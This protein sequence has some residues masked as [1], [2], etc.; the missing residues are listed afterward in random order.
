MEYQEHGVCVSPS[1]HGLGVYAT[2][3][4]AECDL[5]GPIAGKVIDDPAYQ[6]DYCM[7]LGL[8]SALEP[9]APF[10]FVNHSCQPNCRLL[11]IEPNS[12]HQVTVDAGELWLEVLCIIAPGEQITIDYAWPA[13]A[14]TPCRC[15]CPECRGWIVAAT[16][17]H[18]VD[19]SRQSESASR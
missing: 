6:S 18:D 10:R 14:A 16:E 8:H 11:E 17:R 3:P 19:L 2:K 7:E 12:A 1:V 4:F 13:A 15:G 9:E 5:I